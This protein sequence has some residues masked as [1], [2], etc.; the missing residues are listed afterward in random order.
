MSAEA[1]RRGGV[2]VL[3]AVWATGCLT[4]EPAVGPE[5]GRVAVCGGMS[6]PPGWPGEAEGEE[7]LGPFLECGGPGDFVEMQG[8]VDMPRVV[9]RLDEWRAVRLGALGPVRED[10]AGVLNGKRAAF[11]RRASER[12][13]AAAE[14]LALYVLHTATDEDVKEVLRRLARE[15]VLGATVGHMPAVGEELERRGMRLGEDREGEERAGDV[16]RG[17]G[18]GGGAGEVGGG[19][20]RGGGEVGGSRQTGDGAR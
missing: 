9:G 6:A 7:L 19:R 20:G 12:Y 11:L 16:G 15:K 17:L 3:V 13:G 14:V 4:L 18:G 1:L 2:A 5:E 10:A 8:G